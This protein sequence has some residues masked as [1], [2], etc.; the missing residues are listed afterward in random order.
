ML[1]P[2]RSITHSPS[3]KR[4]SG[5]RRLATLWWRAHLISTVALVGVG[6][7]VPFLG[8]DVVWSL[9]V[10]ALFMPLQVFFAIGALAIWVANGQRVATL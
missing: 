2:Y 5:S 3:L 7:F 8:M 9:V 1:R 4:A 10:V 6:L